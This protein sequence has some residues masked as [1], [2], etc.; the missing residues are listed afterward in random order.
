[1]NDVKDLVSLLG[2]NTYW[3]IIAILL[4]VCLFNYDKLRIF[5]TDFWCCLAKTIGWGKRIAT[6]RKLEDI[7]HK[8][9]T[10]ITQEVPELELPSLKINWIAEK[11][12]NVV[13]N[14]G[15]AIVFLKFNPDN[16]QNIINV[17]SAYVKETVLTISKTY[18]SPKISDAIDY[19]VI[20]KCLNEIQ[21][22]RFALSH[23]I[24]NNQEVI[25]QSQTEIDKI[26]NIDDAGLMS[27]ILFR[28]Y[29][30]WG[31]RIVGRNID[32]KYQK[33]ASGF[34]DFLYN[35]TS[36]GYD[37]NTQLQYISENIKVGVLLV[38]KM[39]TF[40]EKGEQP[41]VRRIR[42]GFAKGIRT[43][44]L[45]ARNEKLD[46][47]HDVYCKL[48][49]SGNYE[50]LNG[51]KEYKDSLGRDNICYCIEINSKGDLAKTYSDINNAIEAKDIVE[52][53]ITSVRTN[54][55]LCL[56][57][58]IEVRI[59]RENITNV[60]DLKLYQYFKSGNTIEFIP[61]E[62][63][64]KCVIIGSILETNS[65]PQKMI[66]NKFSVGSNVVAIVDNPEDDF[67]WFRVKDSDMRAIAFRKNLTYS[68]YAFLHHL[69]PV[70]TEHSFII[71]DI[72]YI[73]NK[74]YLKLSDLV[75]PWDNIEF[76]IGQEVVCKVMQKKDNC[77]IT[78]ITDGVRAILPY[79]ETSWFESEINLAKRLKINDNFSARIKSI[80]ADERIVILMTKS[81]ES[82]YDVYYYNTLVQY[83]Y[84]VKAKIVFSDSNGV[85][86]LIEDKYRVFIPQSETHIGDNYHKYKIGKYDKVYIK[87][88]RSDR[89]SFIGS[90]KPFIEHPMQWFSENYQPGIILS[91]LSPSS[92]SDKCVLFNIKCNNRKSV[93]GILPIS[94]ITNLCYLDSL[95]QLY[96]TGR[97]FPLVITN[98]DM[99]QC[100]VMLSLKN[101]LHKNKER[102]HILD[103]TKTYNA[104]I[105]KSEAHRCV[106]II[107]NI[108]IEGV[109]SEARKF[110]GGEKIIV[111]PI[112]LNDTPEF[113]EEQE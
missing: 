14:D 29:F 58:T 44:Y 103:Y 77:I 37:D 76:K 20:K 22:N 113:I 46:I 88:V 60:K 83:D 105:V 69:F 2:L 68:H 80:N 102:I 16:T 7:C 39:E 28:E 89:R 57:N 98:I 19:T 72:D 34:L 32:E 49:Q 13:I 27:R 24:K 4:F 21:T 93:V 100:V 38:A 23:F 111:R 50:L 86:G 109:L 43:F 64:A 73:S 107:E 110:V 82:P 47:V 12:E 18:M 95:K 31:N 84:T 81:Q 65:N 70:G 55:L 75:D 52:A 62:I 106:I 3:A 101:L 59:P 36:R 35:I 45:L 87:S 54:E 11:E 33:E 92:I 112:S 67:V 78:E 97:T 63:D 108:W 66:N 5:I 104:Y 79:T 96:K 30:E 25:K 56:I 99:N 90:Y 9:F 15:E 42:E 91:K 6:K 41:Y 51:P 40:V 1:M 94:E 85:Y 53:V 48:M 61:E 74:L 26:G 17:T 8:S 10:S 71:D